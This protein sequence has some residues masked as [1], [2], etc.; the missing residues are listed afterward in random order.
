MNIRLV[1]T[2]T[3]LV[4]P[5]IFCVLARLQETIVLRFESHDFGLFACHPVNS[6]NQV[7]EV[8]LICSIVNI[9]LLLLWVLPHI[10]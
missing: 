5:L 8:L 2:S 6:I 3:I 10:L 4:K 1:N 7:A 9:R